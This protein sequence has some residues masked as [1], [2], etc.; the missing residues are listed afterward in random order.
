MQ[1]SF[2]NE[3]LRPPEAAGPV[4]SL[5]R[6]AFR[7]GLFGPANVWSYPTF[8]QPRV[9]PSLVARKAQD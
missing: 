3:M 1:N 2:D 8:P 6:D 5:T 7:F 4:T 9:M